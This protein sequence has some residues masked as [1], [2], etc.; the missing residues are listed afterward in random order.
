MRVNYVLYSGISYRGLYVYQ[1]V[2]CTCKLTSKEKISHLIFLIN[3]PGR[4]RP[5]VSTTPPCLRASHLIE[6]KQKNLG[7]RSSQTLRWICRRLSFPFQS[8]A[9]GTSCASHF[10]WRPVFIAEVVYRQRHPQHKYSMRLQHH[11]RREYSI[12]IYRRIGRVLSTQLCWY[13]QVCV[14][15]PADRGRAKQFVFPASLLHEATVH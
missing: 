9:G 6:T 11:P 2:P 13:V 8:L 1:Y 14:S 4:C 15:I 7:H 3:D 10:P 12:V 5:P